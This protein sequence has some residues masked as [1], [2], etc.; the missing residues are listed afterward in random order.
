MFIGAVGLF[1]LIIMKRFTAVF[2]PRIH[3][4]NLIMM[5]IS[6]KPKLKDIPQK[7]FFVLFKNA[8]V[9]KL[10]ERMNY[11]SR[12]KESKV[13]WKLYTVNN[14]ELDVGLG[15]TAIQEST[16]IIDEIWLLTV[17]VV[18]YDVQFSDFEI[19]LWLDKRIS[20][21]KEIHI[22]DFRGNVAGCQLAYV[23]NTYKYI[24]THM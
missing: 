24:N 1:S 3:N 18:L 10:K 16:G 21:F 14:L 6:D 2:L 12:L 15:N 19:I 7:D 11:Y 17:L 4:L 20:F 23:Y 9:K 22:E 13:I 8:K 5:K